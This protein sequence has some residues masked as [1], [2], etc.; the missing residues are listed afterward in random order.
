MTAEQQAARIHVYY[1]NTMFG[2]PY[3]DDYD[4]DMM[5]QLQ[6]HCELLADCLS[7][8]YGGGEEYWNNVKHE[9]RNK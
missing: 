7:H 6:Q 9:I 1:A 5:I 8:C 3:P 4:K 2:V